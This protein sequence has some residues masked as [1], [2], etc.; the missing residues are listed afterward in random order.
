MFQTKKSKII[1]RHI[2]SPSPSGEGSGTSVT[3]NDRRK[4]GKEP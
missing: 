4:Y 2:P 3:R 1:P